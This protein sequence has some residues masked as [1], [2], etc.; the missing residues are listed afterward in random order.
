MFYDSKKKIF[1]KQQQSKT[2]WVKSKNKL[3][4]T[5]KWSVPYDEQ[6]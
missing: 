3:K 5:H 6:N 1:K 2:K 4:K